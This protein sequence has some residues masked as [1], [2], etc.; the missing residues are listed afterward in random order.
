MSVL[1]VVSSDT[2]MGFLTV[3]RTAINVLLIQMGDVVCERGNLTVGSHYNIYPC[4]ICHHPNIYL[5]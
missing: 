4:N 2:T 3:V 5:S 1:R